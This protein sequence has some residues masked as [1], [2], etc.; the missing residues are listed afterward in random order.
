MFPT[1]LTDL[2]ALTATSIKADAVR[3]ALDSALFDQLVTPMHTEH[4]AE[5]HHWATQQTAPL[6]ELLWSMKLLT[7]NAAG[8]QTAPEMQPYLCQAGERFIG[9]SWHFRYQTLREVGQ[10]LPTLMTQTAAPV[11]PAER[12]DSGWA[13]AAQH[14]IAQEQRALTVDRACAIV[15]GLP[16]FS[17]ARTLVDV[18]GGPGLIAIGLTQQHPTLQGMVYDLPQTAAVAQRNIDAAGLGDRLQATSGEFSAQPFAHRYADLIW[19]SSFLHFVDDVATMARQL[20][21]ALTPG[22]VLVAAHAEITEQQ[23]EAAAVL[24]F[25]LPLLLRGRHVTHEGELAAL[26]CDAGFAS[27]ETRRHQPFPMTPLTLLIARK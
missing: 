20:Y 22:G 12:M 9:A 27:V 7:R 15:S 1:T 11:V 23:E 10:Q 19:C 2:W 24:P 17:R 26:L 14:Q 5:R 4:V 16:E 25:Y 8:Y 21:D 3:L 6:L 18:G 13:Q